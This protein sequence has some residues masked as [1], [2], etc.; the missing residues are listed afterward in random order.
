MKQYILTLIL[1][2]CSAVCSAQ[3]KLPRLIS[4]GM[5]LQR[6][7]KI[8]IWGWASP[9]EKIALKFRDRV[10]TTTAIK[11][12][13]WRI[14]LPSQ[15]AGGP[16]KMVLMGTNKIVI[17]NILFGDVYLCSGQSNME[18]TMGRVIDKYPDEFLKTEHPNIRQFLVPDE[19]DFKSA[20]HDLSNGT[21]ESVNQKTLS[22]F[23]AVAYFFALEIVKKNNVPVGIINAALGGSPAQ[24]WISEKAIKKFP[25]YL[26]EVQKFKNDLLIRQIETNDKRLADNWHKSLNNKDEGLKK[27]WKL[28]LSDTGWEEMTV[29]GY[30]SDGPLGKVNGIFWFKKH[31]HVPASMLG[32]PI[33][34]LLGRIVDADSVFING[35]FVGATSYQY[36]P[37]RYLLHPDLLTLGE[38]TITIKLTNNAG[39]GGFIKD[40]SYQL[41]AGLDTINLQ[42]K[43]KYRLGAKTEPAPSQTFIRWKPVGLY[44]AMIAPLVNYQIKA[45]LWYQGESNTAKPLEYYRL[46][47][48]LINN[49]RNEW[50]ISRLPFLFVQLPNFMEPKLTP[51]ESK[52]AELRE[53]QRK[54]INIRNTAMVVAIDLG[55][56]NDI[57][58]LNKRS[59]GERLALQ[60]E[61]LVYRNYNLVSSG[62]LLHSLES[63]GHQ[64]TLTFLYTGTGLI[65]KGTDELR[66]FSIAGKD[67]V[68]VWAKARIEGNKVVVW[69]EEVKSPIYVRYA[70]ADN[71]EGAN[72]YN[73]EGLPAS[74][75]EM[76]LK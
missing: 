41:I 53:Q 61:S 71:P 56:W 75:F 45:V 3:I 58:P 49:W 68:F 8:P 46:M 33:K 7:T 51:A 10:Y 66:Y 54:L 32:K 73:R 76:G 13:T 39:E 24:A 63:N 15:N 40:K 50:K 67:K 29:P 28:N 44:N 17:D 11:N 18:L 21:W 25:E 31:I 35:K 74:P 60:A 5:V 1:A 57:H 2:L 22:E 38:N 9:G 42:G 14:S 23:S 70:W 37:R 47:E 62:P 6:H 16:D 19:Y 52:W 20:R 65:A 12:G 26:K 43:W 72:L 59:V 48:G 27:N 4:S 36:P 69:S 64:L 55:E 30:W 34:L